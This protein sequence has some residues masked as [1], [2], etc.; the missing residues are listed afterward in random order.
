[1][2]LGPVLDVAFGLAFVFA[3]L[4]IIASSIQEMIASVLAT[5]GK[6]LQGMMVQILSHQPAQAPQPGQPE[7]PGAPAAPAAAPPP[8]PAPSLATRVLGHPLIASLA[9]PNLPA[10]LSNLLNS[11]KLPSYVPSGN[12]ATALIE[13]LREGHDETLAVGSQVSRAIALLPDNSP[14]KR[15]LQGFMIE[16]RGDLD[17]FRTRVQTWYNDAMDRASGVYKRYAQYMLLGIGLVLAVAINADAVGIA[18]TL[19][20][21]K[22]MRD[23]VATAATQDIAGASAGRGAGSQSASSGSCS[24]CC[25]PRSCG[26]VGHASN[27]ADQRGKQGGCSTAGAARLGQCRRRNVFRPGAPGGTQDTGLPGDCL[28]NFARCAVLVRHV[29]K[30]RQPAWRRSET[31]SSRSG[32][33]RLIPDACRPD[34]LTALIVTALPAHG[35]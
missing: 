19:W 9:T 20:H 10:W 12:F 27:R 2:T 29:A 31:C 1:M 5:R 35:R 7:P 18:D 26:W 8:P 22:N 28:C 14:V 24:A 30:H 16:A 33:G 25:E 17:A 6:V 13:T 21:D 15:S 34:R 4:A 23:V 32:C 3:L 11:A